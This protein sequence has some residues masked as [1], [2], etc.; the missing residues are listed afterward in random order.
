MFRANTSSKNTSYDCFEH[1]VFEKAES[2]K[3]SEKIYFKLGPKLKD[4][5]KT[6]ELQI[7]KLQNRSYRTKNCSRTLKRPEDLP[8][9]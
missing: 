2:K 8:F 7:K 6:S 3:T 9:R 1:E 4:I 5:P